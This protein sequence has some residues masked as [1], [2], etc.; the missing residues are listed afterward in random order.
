MYTLSFNS[1]SEIDQCHKPVAASNG[2]DGF[3]FLNM[4]KLPKTKDKL[5]YSIGNNYTEIRGN[6][7]SLSPPVSQYSNPNK[8]TKGNVFICGYP[9]QVNMSYT[10]ALVKCLGILQNDYNSKAII[11]CRFQAGTFSHQMK[12]LIESVGID[13]KYVGIAHYGSTKQMSGSVAVRVDDKKCR[14]LG[15]V[16]SVNRLSTVVNRNYVNVTVFLLRN[17]PNLCQMVGGDTVKITNYFKQN[18]G[19]PMQLQRKICSYIV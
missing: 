18:Y 15:M 10:R 7:I 19:A 16:M 2:D 3:V 17:E 14:L 4:H 12:K 11:K 5:N 6:I 8:S 9:T 13:S 1:E